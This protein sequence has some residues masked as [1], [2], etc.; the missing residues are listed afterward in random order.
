MKFYTSYFYQIRNFTPNMIPLSTACGDPK[1]YHADRDKN[2]VYFDNNR[3]VN[4]LRAEM[5]HPDKTCA[6]L[7]EG[8][9]ACPYTPDVCAFLQAYKYQLD[10]VDFMD[11]IERCRQVADSVR[12]CNHFE[13]EPIIV[14]MVH[15]A[16][17]N[18]C[19]E[20]RTIQNW[21][22]S[23]GIACPELP[24]QGKQFRGFFR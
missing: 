15:E 8:A 9:F 12:E 1:W 3:V 5:L 2:F 10:R 21:M 7:C 23:H 22:T 17:G 20:R 16:Y 11:F 14:L 6:G 13:G 19:S 18:P 4:G 24:Y